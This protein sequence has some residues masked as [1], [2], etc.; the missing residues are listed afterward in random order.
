VESHCFACRGFRGFFGE[1]WF[2][3]FIGFFE[4]QQKGTFLGDEGPDFGELSRAGVRGLEAGR[5]KA[6]G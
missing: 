3:S 2:Y 6:E 4:A 1:A 5:M